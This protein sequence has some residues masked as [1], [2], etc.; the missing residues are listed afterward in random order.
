MYNIGNLLFEKVLN[1]EI[2]FRYIGVIG[3]KLNRKLGNILKSIGN[4]F[5]VFIEFICDKNILDFIRLRNMKF[6]DYFDELEK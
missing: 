6:I 1:I 3:E 2:S 4:F 5:N